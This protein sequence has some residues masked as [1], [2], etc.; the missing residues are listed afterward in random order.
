MAR[1]TRKSTRALPTRSGKKSIILIGSRD[2]EDVRR[3][4]DNVTALI[5]DK[6]NLVAADLDGTLDLENTKADLVVVFGGDGKLL[7]VARRLGGNQVP[8]VGVN[9]GKFGFLAEFE[10]EEFLA[11]LDALLS[12]D[13]GGEGA[14]P[15][16]YRVRERMLLEVSVRRAGD[17]VFSSLAMNDAVISRSH[18]SRIIQV[19]LQVDGNYCTRYHVDGIILASP[20]GSTA[21]SLGAGGPIVHPSMDAMI[22]APIC[23]HTMSVRPLVVPSE[24]EL[25]LTLVEKSDTVALTVDGQVFKELEL[26]DVV[27]VTGAAAR[28]Q[29]VESGRR[30]FYE[31]LQR[32]L[33]WAGHGNI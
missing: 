1:G 21:H 33:N 28:L 22:I 31:T 9:F 12:E 18:F 2:R 23:P 26:G 13:L 5:I 15:R 6:A 20:S 7:S 29:L 16:R 8:V 27:T 14:H 17:V 32:K 4:V 25:Q 24:S 19:Q 3:A 11:S 30:N 10:H